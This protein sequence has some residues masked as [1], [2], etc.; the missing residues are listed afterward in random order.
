M[1]NGSP[2][3]LTGWGSTGSSQR[4]SFS[5]GY[6]PSTALLR[7]AKVPDAG[8]TGTLTIT[9]RAPAAAIPGIATEAFLH[10]AH[11]RVGTVL[12]ASA[13]GTGV[14][15]RIVAAIRAFPAD[16]AGGGALIVDQA[17]LQQIL[18]S[19]EATPLPVTEWWLATRQSSPPPVL[20]GATVTSRAALAAALLGNS[21]AAPPRQA[22]LAVG[23]AAAL[24]A[25][26]GFSISV[27]ASVRGRRAES[28][29][30]SALG[31][32]RSAQ[33]CQLCL[34]Q[35]MLSVPA[36]AA[37][38]LLGAGLAWLV[39]PSVTL[40]ASACRP[41]PPV[42]VQIPVGWAAL[43]A[44]AVAA[45]PVLA[46]AASILRRPDPAVELRAAEAS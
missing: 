27:A 30:L 10:A 1:T 25:V 37:G 23:L 18:A 45:L 13:N 44:A 28:A 5:P 34:E 46:A 19:L 42:L 6:T 11:A 39:V 16:T 12:T 40:T 15:V 4:L 43:L 29:V 36:A 9:A 24:L 14:Q 8:F 17:R 3:T 20:R 26:I 22:A 33:A 41:Q 38:L 21:L 2:P 31:V 35:L 7:A 32:A